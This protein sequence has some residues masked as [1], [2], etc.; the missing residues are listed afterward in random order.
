MD[1]MIFH[2]SGPS[3][4]DKTYLGNKLKEMFKN[5]KVVMDIDDLRNEFIKKEYG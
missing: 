5:K 4:S 2:I 3:G 1:K